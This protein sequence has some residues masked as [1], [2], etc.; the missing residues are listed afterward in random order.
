MKIAVASK[1]HMVSEHFGHCPNFNFFEIVDGNVL[2]EQFV[3]SPGHDCQALP[4]F[5][6]DN[7]MDVVISGGMGKGAMNN[8]TT[9][10]LTAVTG[11]RGLAK[12]AAIA[13]ERGKLVS[14][15]ELCS[16]DHGHNHHE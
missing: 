4:Q 11:A 5:L 13:F 16:R 2:K 8:L 14:S 12:D 6:K 15:G 1:E 10:G 7:G 9:N 3:P